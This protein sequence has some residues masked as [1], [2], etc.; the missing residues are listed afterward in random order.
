MIGSASNPNALGQSEA[1]MH[2]VEGKLV[3]YFEMPCALCSLILIYPNRCA[4]QM[5]W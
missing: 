5:V 4:E 2:A 3:C 1:R